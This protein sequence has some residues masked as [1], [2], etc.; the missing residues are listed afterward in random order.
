MTSNSD[1]YDALKNRLRLQLKKNLNP[2]L[3]WSQI[4]SSD[5]DYDCVLAVL[6]MFVWLWLSDSYFYP[7]PPGI[8]GLIYM[9]V[10]KMAGYR[11][12]V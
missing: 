4:L 3:I 1:Y 9:S 5:Y 10:A 6:I 8:L 11:Q 2:D 12:S 7:P